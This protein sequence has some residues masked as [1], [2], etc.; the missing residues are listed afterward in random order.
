M[1]KDIQLHPAQLAILRE[2]LYKPEAR[3]S[4][5]NVTN[6]T[7][8]HF[9]FHIQQLI[10]AALVEKSEG[11]KYKLTSSGKEFANRF[12][13]DTP[14]NITIEKQAKIG[15]AVCCVD[16]QDGEIKYLLQQRLK[17]PYYGYWGCMTGKIKWGESVYETAKRELEEEMG[18]Q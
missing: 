7:S 15:V 8:D 14:N 13:T 9:N 2:L 11:A 10:H 1:K 18:V 16:T 5:L 4:E 17:Q 3:F 6:L 12:D